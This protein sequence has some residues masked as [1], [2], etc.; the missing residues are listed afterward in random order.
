MFVSSEVLRELVPTGGRD[1]LNL[2][3][4]VW[5]LVSMG[6]EC[7]VPPT[8]AR[9]RVGRRKVRGTPDDSPD[10][11]LAQRQAEGSIVIQGRWVVAAWLDILVRIVA[12]SP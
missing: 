7:L 1:S 6:L 3:G 10:A 12:R 9:L 11:A 8:V 5:V 2:V 4:D